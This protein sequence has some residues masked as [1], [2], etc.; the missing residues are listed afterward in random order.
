M[1]CKNSVQDNLTYSDADKL[2]SRHVFTVYMGKL[3][4]FYKIESE[5]G[6]SF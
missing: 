2:T 1:Q 3:I 4:T 6:G 5:K